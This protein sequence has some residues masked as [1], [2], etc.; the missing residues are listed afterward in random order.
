T[1]AVLLMGEGN[2][3]GALAKLEAGVG[4]AWWRVCGNFPWFGETYPWLGERRALTPL[5]GDP[6][7]E[8]V[9]TRCRTEINKQR[10]LAGMAPAAL[11]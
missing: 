6:R 10:K 5:G 7:F 2:R 9:K 11:K 8:A 4:T 1:W 3:A